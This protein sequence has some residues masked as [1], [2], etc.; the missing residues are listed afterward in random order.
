MA[1]R[2]TRE[3]DNG[4]NRTKNPKPKSYKTKQ[5]NTMDNR[6]TNEQKGKSFKHTGCRHMVGL[7]KYRV[8]RW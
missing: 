2:S 6:A 3:V 4:W 5:P 8:E 1:T 7:V